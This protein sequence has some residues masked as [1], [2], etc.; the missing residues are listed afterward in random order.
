MTKDH[1]PRQPAILNE[2]PTLRAW[3]IALSVVVIACTALAWG[4]TL[5]P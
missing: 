4:L 5:L 1:E 3:V 2:G